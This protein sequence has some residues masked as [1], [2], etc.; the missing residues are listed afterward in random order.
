MNN[1]A[2]IVVAY[3]RPDSLN[4]LLVSLQTA[5][6][7]SDS[8]QLIISIDGGENERVKDIATEF[9]WSHGSKEI[10]CHWNH[11]GLKQHVFYCGDLTQK[12]GNIILLEDDLMVSPYFYQFAVN[13][14]E[15]YKDVTEIAGL[16]LYQYEITENGFFPFVPIDDEYSTYFMQV[17]SSWGQAWTAQQWEGFKQW[18][19]AHEKRT[20]SL[21]PQYVKQWP[22]TSWKKI[23]FK[24]LID[25]DRY[26]VFP[27]QSY[28]TN[29]GDPGTHADRQGLFQISLSMESPSVLLAPFMKFCTRYDAWFELLPECLKHRAP[30]LGN[31]SL[32]VD[33][34]GTKDLDTINSEFILTTRRSTQAEQSF[35]MKM[36]PAMQN[37]I[38]DVP[39]NKINLTRKKF[40]I[41]EPLPR[42]FYYYQTASI[43]ENIYN[44]LIAN[45]A[46]DMGATVFN[47][48]KND[49]EFQQKNPKLL[50]ITPVYD[51]V[52]A[53]DIQQITSTCSYPNLK[54]VVLDLSN[55]QIELNLPGEIEH[56]RDKIE[57]LG[58]AIDDII[59]DVNPEMIMIVHTGAQILSQ[60]AMIAAEVFT[61]C[62]DIQWLNGMGISGLREDQ[63][64]WSRTRLQSLSNQNINDSLRFSNVI[65]KRHLWETTKDNILMN[66][67][68]TEFH[69]WLEFAKHTELRT[70]DRPF[71]DVHQANNEPLHQYASPDNDNIS[72][73]QSLPHPFIRRLL[74]F[75]LYPGYRF[76]IPL[77][78]T[79]YAELNR[80]PPLL[81][82]DEQRQIC[83]PEW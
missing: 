65:F 81:H 62:Q 60:T 83:Y 13:A 56:F 49:M 39:G 12:Y 27:R 42:H 48:M 44:D 70:I 68:F 17:P 71:T 4:R 50:V 15:F 28:T 22:E 69:L 75:V 7:S 35:G 36:I 30:N 59:T 16:S 10:I 82:W 67:S 33:L 41:D 55:P 23:F 58:P 79:I 37:V 46:T 72:D 1:P 6:F 43:H 3:N 31:T 51:Q 80:I 18:L 32:T 14:L 8:I 73:A 24:Y 47:K 57:N 54:Y 25:T 38:H 74:S 52:S 2:I 63:C 61:K 26:F 5:S 76:R 11:L 19:T 9:Q 64:R 29:F 45:K 53:D 34:Y 21:L 40:V 77:I 78:R 20:E 66:S